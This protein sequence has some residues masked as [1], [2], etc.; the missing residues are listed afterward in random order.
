MH[1]QAVPAASHTFSLT[2][3]PNIL[4]L[5]NLL[6]LESFFVLLLFL[7]SCSPFALGLVLDC[8]FLPLHVCEPTAAPEE[9][10]SMSTAGG[11]GSVELS[12]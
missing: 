9:G 4:E 10:M 11:Q 2:L 8:L 5:K 12:C 6:D 1:G 7:N 3:H